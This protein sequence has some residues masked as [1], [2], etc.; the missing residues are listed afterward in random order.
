MTGQPRALRARSFGGWTLHE[1]DEV[2]S[3]NET[4]R[5]MPAWH[6]VLA[7]RQTHGRGRHGRTWLSEEAGGLCLSAVIATP[8]PAAKWTALPLAAGLAVVESLAPQGLKNL[9]LRWPNDI[10]AGERKLGGVLVDHFHPDRA[11]VGIGLNVTS[12]PELRGPESDNTPVCLAELTSGVPEPRELAEWILNDLAK[13]CATF[14]ATGLATLGGYLD[15]LWDK[16]RPVRL[17]LDDDP[18]PVEGLFDG[19]D[20]NGALLLKGRPPLPAERVRKLT[21]LPP[22]KT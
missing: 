11:V 7:A 15:E 3:T 18:D 17:L 21:E 9:R 20:A 22:S 19:I 8:G 4:A 6:A 1:F 10:M 2:A 16:G 14:A 5:D 13:V 12:R